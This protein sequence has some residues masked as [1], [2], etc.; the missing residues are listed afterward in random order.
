MN[1]LLLSLPGTPVLY[2]GD[3]IGWATTSISVIATEFARRCSGAPIATV[4]SLREPQKLYLPT[5]I[6]P[7]YHYEAVNV[8]AQQSNTASLLWWMK[9]L[10]AKRKEHRLFGR[11][12][13]EFMTGDNPR[14]LY[15]CANSKASAFSSSRTCR[16]SCSVL[17]SISSNSRAPFPPSVRSHELSGDRRCAV[18]R[19]AWTARLL[20]AR[21]DQP[22][23][24]ETAA[25]RPALIAKES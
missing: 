19:L 22:Q 11:G 16:A 5:I 4:G 23:P 17:A 20:L 12:S 25:E 1:A 10:L 18:L 8:E 14:V 9:R 2:Y 7:E 6:D 21:A 24:V 3:E 13:I 15:S